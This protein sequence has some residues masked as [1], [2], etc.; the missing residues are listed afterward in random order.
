MGLEER[1]D[2]IESVLRDVIR[3][4]EELEKLLGGYRDEVEATRLAA[5]LSAT[6]IYPAY[7]AVEAA[8]RI[9]RVARHAGPLD[10][11]SRS[12]VEALSACEPATISEITRRVREI[13]GTAS[14]RIVS[15]RVKRLEER[16]LVVKLGEGPRPG[17]TLRE[18]LPG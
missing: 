15:E 14:R 1:L 6:G 17:Y 11:I 2:R 9:L 4:L 18:C 16:G 10:P 12:V 13:R 5:R 7:A 3:R 8:R